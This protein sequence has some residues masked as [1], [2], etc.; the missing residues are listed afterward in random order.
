MKKILPKLLLGLIFIAGVVYF[1]LPEKEIKG[2]TDPEST[3]YNPGATIDDSSCLVEKLPEKIKEKLD[4]L[5]QQDWDKDNYTYTR[6]FI[7][8]HYSSIGKDGTSE[9]DNAIHALDMS[10]L[11][12]LKKAVETLDN[13]LTDADNV[14]SEVTIFHNKYKTES[15]EIQKAY[16]WFKTESNIT[17][18]N[19]RVRYLLSQ[20]YNEAAYNRLISSI[21]ALEQDPNYK[22]K[23]KNCNDFSA[24]LN[25]AKAN[26]TDFD[27]GARLYYDDFEIASQVNKTQWQ[28]N[29]EVHYKWKDFFKVR[30]WT[31]YHNE[32]MKIDSQLKQGD[33]Y[34]DN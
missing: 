7:K 30:G 15:S 27:G 26:L 28:T 13:C 16:S 29:R 31:W 3:N 11:K 33:E 8:Q 19:G 24:T 10:Y 1:L 12:V 9:E 32:V 14:K 23:M 18:L 22:N 2:C 25:T 20:E 4:S 5:E 34:Y 17:N 6:N 21:N